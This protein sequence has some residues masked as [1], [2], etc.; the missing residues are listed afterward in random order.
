MK[1]TFLIALLA[2]IL[3]FVFVSISHSEHNIIKLTEN[4]YDDR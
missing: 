2:P 3:P 1:R 4:S